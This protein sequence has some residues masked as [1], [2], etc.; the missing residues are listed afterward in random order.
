MYFAHY[1]IEKLNIVKFFELLRCDG[2]LPL[3][4]VSL[5]LS[6][7]LEVRGTQLSDPAHNPLI[8]FGAIFLSI[9]F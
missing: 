2:D 8:P 7:R 1:A 4:F 3:F 6:L 5:S 9:D